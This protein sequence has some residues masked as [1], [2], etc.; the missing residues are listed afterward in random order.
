MSP[1]GYSQNL[2][3]HL[4]LAEATRSETAK[5][6][7]IS[8]QPTPEHLE[9]MTALAEAIF[10]P[11]RTFIG[12][13]LAVNSLYRSPE[14]NKAIKGAS[15]TSDHCRGAAIDMDC[16]IYGGSN[17]DLF[18]FIVDNL[19]FGQLIWEFGQ[20]P[21]ASNNAAPD[22]VHCS[23]YVD[24]PNKKQILQAYKVNGRT[25]YKTWTDPRG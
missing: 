23:Y 7:G 21:E 17:R 22:W 11:C 18:F 2:S 19:D 16:D 12:R 9:N 5:R 14:L 25:K 15:A 8:N 6:H 24:R 3:K 10:E 1:K 20:E 4:T 13:P